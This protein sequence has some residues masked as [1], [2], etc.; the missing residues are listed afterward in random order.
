MT[1]AT[2]VL[3][4]IFEADLPPEQ[5]AYR[6]EK[7][8]LDAVRHVHTLL[9]SR[10]WEVVD[11][12]LSGYFDTIPHAELMKSVSRRIVDRHVLRLIKI[13]VMVNAWRSVM[14]LSRSVHRS[15]RGGKTSQIGVSRDCKPSSANAMP[16]SAEVTL[17]VTERRS[18]SV[19]RSNTILWSCPAS[20]D[21]FHVRIGSS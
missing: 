2:L 20:V 14:V 15:A 7:S 4:P 19:S 13:G 21:R 11:A 18:W 3:A 5:Y 1:A 8:A 16:T 12:D 9:T 10:H 17:L 6:P